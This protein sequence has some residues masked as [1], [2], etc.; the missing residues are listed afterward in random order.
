M[1]GTKDE[2]ALL[3]DVKPSPQPPGR[4]TLVS[5]R[6]GT[7]LVQVAWQSPPAADRR[8]LGEQVSREA[9]GMS[10]SS[11]LGPLVPRQHVGS[12]IRL[13]VAIDLVSVG[14]RGPSGIGR[15]QQGIGEVV[16][17]ATEATGAELDDRR[18]HGDGLQLAFRPVDDE[19]AVLRA[20]Y[21]ELLAALREY[22]RDLR[23]EAA[24]RLRVG[25]DRGLFDRSSLGWG[26]AAPIVSARLRD[27]AQA[28]MALEENPN[29]LFVLVVS[30]ML[31]RDIFRDPGDELFGTTFTRIAIEDTGKGF[32]GLAWLH[33]PER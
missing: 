19:R 26:G 11:A 1:S 12:V 7:G 16:D 33:V 2:G 14:Q 17:R 15:A 30:D 8:D 24:L 28:R 18:E 5:R 32:Y 3:A 10:E 6:H 21:S 4:G 20:F 27:S 22:N 29:A 31:Y 9:I 23:P 25:I 13:F